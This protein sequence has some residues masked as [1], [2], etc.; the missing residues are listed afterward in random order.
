MTV[1]QFGK[2]L[3]SSFVAGIWRGQFSLFTN[4]PNNFSKTSNNKRKQHVVG[5]TVFTWFA[6]WTPVRVIVLC[7]WG[8]TLNS[9]HA[10][11]CPEVQMKPKK[12]AMD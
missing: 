4:N 9:H 3:S 11:L 2:L 8:K 6:R 7:F 12:L 5:D 1:V 10:S